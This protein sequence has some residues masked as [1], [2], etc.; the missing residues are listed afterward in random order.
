MNTTRHTAEQAIGSAM[1]SVHSAFTEAL[2]SFDSALREALHT[3]DGN[4]AAEPTQPLSFDSLY[5][6]IN[7]H[8]MGRLKQLQPPPLDRKGNVK[9]ARNRTETLYDRLMG[10]SDRIVS[11]MDR[12]MQ[13]VSEKMAA[14]AINGDGP[15][16]VIAHTDG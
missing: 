8:V 3:S 10:M 5:N 2:D 11:N 6:R 14:E 9:P 7:N 13:Q 12:K 16:S 15:V 1:S 4:G